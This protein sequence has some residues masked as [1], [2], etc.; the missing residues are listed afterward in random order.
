MDIQGVVMAPESGKVESCTQQDVELVAQ[1]IYCVSRSEP[2]L[3]FEIDDASRPETDF[4][5][6]Y[7]R[8]G[9][10]TRLNHPRDRP[11]DPPGPGHLHHPIRR[12][13]TLPRS[14]AALGSS[15]YSHPEALIGGASEGQEPG[16]V[17]ARL[18]GPAACL[19]Q[20]AAGTS[21][22]RWSR[23]WSGCSRLARCLRWKTQATH[24]HLC[25]FTGLDMEM[26]IKEHY[27]EVLDVLDNLFLHMFDGLNERFK[28][29]LRSCP[30][31]SRTSPSS[32]SDRR[33]DWSFRKGSR[34]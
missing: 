5:T 28:H 31:S 3:P 17:Q 13:R 9:Q 1:S 23:T 25:E 19:A 4:E 33:F 21:R 30:S 29:E 12:V 2:R 8:V 34:C 16:R 20:S 6:P 22:W 10:D 24:R 7:V 14:A 26:A 18:H 11:E 32:T 15:D 27:F